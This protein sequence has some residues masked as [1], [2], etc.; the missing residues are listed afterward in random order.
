MPPPPK[1]CV[2]CREVGQDGEGIRQ[3]E[4]LAQAV[5]RSRDPLVGPSTLLRVREGKGS[6][7]ESLTQN[8]TRVSVR[9]INHLK[10]GDGS[11]KFPRQVAPGSGD[12]VPEQITLI[13]NMVA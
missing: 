6:P 1:I 12:L 5:Q 13:F 2:G 7:E 4:E 8:F 9:L 3:G 11:G 10:Q